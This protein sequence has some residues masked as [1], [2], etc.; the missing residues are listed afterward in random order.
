MTGEAR[1]LQ[2]EDRIRDVD[3][4]PDGSIMILTDSEDGALVRLTQAG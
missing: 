4:A 2:G 3:V 1:Y